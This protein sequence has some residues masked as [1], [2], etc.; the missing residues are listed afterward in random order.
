M[1]I[2]VAHAENGPDVF[3]QTLARETVGRNAVAHHAAQVLLFFIELHRVPHEREEIGTGETGGAAPDD[4]D[5]ASGIRLTLR[6]RNGVGSRLIAGV[7]FDGADIDRRINERAAAALFAGMLAHIAAGSRKRIVFADQSN[8]FSAAAFG[9]E[10]DVARHVNVRRTEGFAGHRL[11]DALLAALLFRVV[12]KFVSKAGEALEHHLRSVV[13]DGAVRTQADEFRQCFEPAE[14]FGLSFAVHD[15][16]HKLGKL[17]KAVPARHTF[18]AGL[19]RTRFKEAQLQRKRAL[20]WR[21]GFDAPSK[22]VHGFFV[23]RISHRD[24]MNG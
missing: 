19:Q 16:A 8:G 18:A 2:D 10:R 6:G 11:S 5:R 14:I 7:L 15:A 1:D 17:R 9:H 22:T 13:T 21:R 20:S 24:G 4:G 12:L 23:A 3:V